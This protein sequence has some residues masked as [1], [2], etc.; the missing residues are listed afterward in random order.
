VSLITV[1]QY[2]TRRNTNLLPIILYPLWK[3]MEKYSEQERNSEEIKIIEQRQSKRKGSPQKLGELLTWNYI[4]LPL[5]I[6]LLFHSWY[7][8]HMESNDRVTNEELTGNDVEGSSYGSAWGN[9]CLRGLK[10]TIKPQSCWPES[11]RYEAG[12]PARHI[13]CYCCCNFKCLSVCLSVCLCFATSKQSS[14]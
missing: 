11:P 8:R 10:K 9:I 13:Q 14:G 2:N 6:I 1:Y 4:F 12:V 7:Y 3:K 5:F